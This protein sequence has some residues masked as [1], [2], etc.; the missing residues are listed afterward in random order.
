[1]V[2]F[3]A[4]ASRVTWAWFQGKPAR[5]P[6]IFKALFCKGITEFDSSLPKGRDPR[7]FPHLL[8]RKVLS[9]DTPQRMGLA[10]VQ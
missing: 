8:V 9:K 10:L 6:G 5:E 1:M 3:T 2:S 7:H 4:A